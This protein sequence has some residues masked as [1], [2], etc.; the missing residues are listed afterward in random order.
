MMKVIFL[1]IDG[2]LND[3]DLDCEIGM[4]SSDAATLSREMISRVN[5][6]VRCTGA[7]VVISSSWRLSYSLNRIIHMLKT[8]GFEGEVIDK[9]PSLPKFTKTVTLDRSDEIQDWLSAHPE[10]ENFI[11]FDDVEFSGFKVKNFMNFIHIE[12]SKGIQ[13]HHVERAI[14][15]LG[16][17]AISNKIRH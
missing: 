16:C 15:I 8:K 12:N 5:K 13:D 14:D 1:D 11:V 4:Y 3:P 10:V 2:V 6:V 7:K 17:K 9:T